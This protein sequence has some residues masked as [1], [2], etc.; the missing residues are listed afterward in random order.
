[1]YKEHIIRLATKLPVCV[2]YNV[3]AKQVNE[4]NQTDKQN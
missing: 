4:M 3:V 2:Q 1:M